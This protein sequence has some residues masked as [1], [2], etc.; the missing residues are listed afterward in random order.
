[1]VEKVTEVTRGYQS[2]DNTPI[3]SDKRNIMEEII[4]KQD[5]LNYLTDKCLEID[6]VIEKFGKDC[7]SMIN[8][9]KTKGDIY[10]PK[11]GFIMRL[12]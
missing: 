5:I 11:P 12:N 10:E 2:E 7:E 1:M 9:M 3:M 8:D 6:E 4:D